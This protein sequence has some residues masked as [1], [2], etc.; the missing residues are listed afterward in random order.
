[1]TYD[2]ATPTDEAIPAPYPK[3]YVAS[4]ERA[5][6]DKPTEQLMDGLG[7]NFIAEFQKAEMDRQPTEDRWLTD[8][9]QYKGKYEPEEET[10]MGN[11]SKSFVR[12]TRVKVK[13]VDSRVGDLLFPAGNDKNWNIEP[14]PVPN[15][16]KDDRQVIVDQLMQAAQQMMQAQ[17]QAQ[18]QQAGPAPD[19]SQPAAPGPQARP[20]QQQNVA[21]PPDKL[22][23]D[24]IMAQVKEAAREM[25]KVIDDQLVEA[26][27][28][29]QAL[30]V[31]HSGHLYGTGVLKGPLVE[32]R[33][34]TRFRRQP[35]LD[36]EKQ[37]T[38]RTKWAPYSERYPVPFVDYVPLWRFYPDMS[39]TTLDQCQF[40]YELHNMTPSQ[41]YALAERSSFNRKRILDHL[42]ANP[43]GCTT[44]R[45]HEVQ[46]QAL[47]ERT[48][49]QGDITGQYEVLERWG[50]VKGCKL[51]EN[52]VE[53]PPD[54]EQESFFC[55]VWLLPDGTIIKAVLQPIDGVTWPYHLYYFDKDETSI[56]GEGLS[57]IMRDDQTMINATTRMIL[58]NAAIT[59]G[60]MLEVVADLLAAG[61]DPNDIRAWKVF[62]RKKADANSG[63]AVKVIEVPN[64]LEDLQRIVNQFD[65][66]ADEVSAIPRYVTGEN[67]TDGAAGTS[68]GL[69]MLMGAVNIVIKDL[70]TGYDE[71]VTVP[72][73]QGLYH[74]NMKFNPKDSIKGD[75]DVYARG[76]ASL[77]AKEVRSRQLNEF[78]Q[79][80]MN[81]E[82]GKFIK[83]HKLMQARAEAL[84]LTDVVMTEDEVKAESEGEAAQRQQQMAMEMQ[85]AQLAEQQAKVGK[86]T[87]DAALA[88]KRAEES[89]VQ[90]QVLTAKV[91]ETLANIDQIVANT[92]ST[93]VEAVFAAL[94]AGGVATSRPTIAP[95]GDEI[96][97][98]SGF[99]DI[100]GDPAIASLNGPPV[101]EDPGTNALMNRGQRFEVE[102]RGDDAPAGDL[103][104]AAMLAQ[105][106]EEA[107]GQPQDEQ[108]MPL[109]T[110]GADGGDVQPD[111]PAPANTDELPSP[112]QM[113]P[114]PQTGMVGR[115]SGMNTDDIENA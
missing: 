42:L 64:H 25:S 23:D 113:T 45:D 16:S 98:S 92:V 83:R 36:A 9:R 75:F 74:W 52:G 85:A 46:L 21:R 96:L 106:Q 71:G 28:K 34:R 14:T 110:D 76:S 1:M 15:V 82:D 55:N 54:R 94:Q 11:R 100:N 22:V 20:M 102:P 65:K 63:P 79:L 78:A 59:S 104:E 95:A 108:G 33:V 84:E 26:R 101:Q 112:G 48:S 2:R 49:K 44:R 24:L 97:R 73:L 88:N 62:L 30:L 66:N 35:V 56:F 17:A 40:I 43:D 58:D 91:K 53:V 114:D 68:S 89:A 67:A 115:R 103:A 81:P 18:A 72:F 38:G 32:M 51:K 60:P 37:P 12:K 7:S 105:Q 6:S 39:A 29:Q 47:G 4:A 8:L 111:V 31:L 19:G 3:E 80:T 10:K 99:K 87:S 61:E 109:P 86:L 13:T 41:L 50:Y 5:F 90:A 107:N 27:Y 57:S 77:V 70:I 69:S 93:R